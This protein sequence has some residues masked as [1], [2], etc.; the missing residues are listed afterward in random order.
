LAR[1][2]CLINVLTSAETV[3]RPMLFRRDNH[4]Q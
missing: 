1:A 4:L 3:G 2:I